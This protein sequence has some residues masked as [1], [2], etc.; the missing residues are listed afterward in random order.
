MTNTD[1]DMRNEQRLRASLHEAAPLPSQ[2][3]N[4]AIMAK[5]RELAA[6]QRRPLI[7]RLAPGMG[8]AASLVLAVIV[9]LWIRSEPLP[10]TIERGGDSAA[11]H[12]L[13][14][15][16]LTQNPT[17][18]EWRGVERADAY[19]VTLYDDTAEVVWES[20]ETSETS[21][22]I[23]ADTEIAA[24]RRYFW[25]VTVG[26]GSSTQELGPFWFER[27]S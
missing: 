12:P 9:G 6:A 7:L 21:V 14:G 27:Q 15:A 26:R 3:H 22:A 1:P 23:P 4:E 19:R 16:V 5:A 18:F 25:V 24:G 20:I 8:I 2:Q 13:D 10:S 11:L 17:R